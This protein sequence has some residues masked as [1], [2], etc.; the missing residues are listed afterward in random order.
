MAISGAVELARVHLSKKSPKYDH[1]PL[2]RASI[3][4]I[5][6]ADLTNRWCYALDFVVKFPLPSPE[7]NEGEWIEGEGWSSESFAVY[8]M[9]DGTI[10]EPEP[11]GTEKTANKPSEATP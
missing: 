1:F 3:K 10:L 9:L 5:Q 6:C 7:L 8:M 11:I 4:S 2:T